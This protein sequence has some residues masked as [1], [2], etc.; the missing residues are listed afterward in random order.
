MFPRLIALGPMLAGL[1]VLGVL[2]ANRLAHGLRLV[3]ADNQEQ[4]A[5]NEPE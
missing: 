1:P 2:I 3:L 5:E 4:V